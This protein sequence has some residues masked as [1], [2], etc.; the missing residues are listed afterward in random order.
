MSQILN[1]WRTLRIQFNRRFSQQDM[2]TGGKGRAIVNVI[3][4]IIILQ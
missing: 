2:L 4:V 3:I 1:L